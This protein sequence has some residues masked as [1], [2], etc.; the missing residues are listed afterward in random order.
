MN[1]YIFKF[2]DGTDMGFIAESRD[3]AIGTAKQSV[4][5]GVSI[6]EIIIKPDRRKGS[7]GIN[8]LRR[9]GE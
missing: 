4:S 3:E 1:Y 7:L 2:S 6:T 9:E 8:E 5:K